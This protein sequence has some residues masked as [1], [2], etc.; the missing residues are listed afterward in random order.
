[1]LVQPTIELPNVL[2]R[3]LTAYRAGDCISVAEAFTSD[4]TLVTQMDH[5]FARM[6]GL[7]EERI[8]A[9]GALEIMQYYAAEFATFEITHLEVLSAMQSGR[10]IAAVCEWGVRQRTTNRQFLGRCHNIWSLDRSGRKLVAGHNV[11][12]IVTPGWDH[13]MN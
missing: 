9:S 13:E 12:K 8:A 11:C 4:A 7:A 3:A 10:D 2:R 6:L 1:M 5:K